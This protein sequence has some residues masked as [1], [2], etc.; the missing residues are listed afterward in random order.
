MVA[1]NVFA[2]GIRTRTHDYEERRVFNGCQ[3]ANGQP[4][5]MN[6]LLQFQSKEKEIQFVSYLKRFQG[7]L[8]LLLC[9]HQNDVRYH[10]RA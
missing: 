9:R 5:D 4:Y 8:Y 2:Q 3:L 10:E 7:E 1:D 6:K